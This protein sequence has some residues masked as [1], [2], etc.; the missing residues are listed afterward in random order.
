MSL[1]IL[2][3]RERQTT[4]KM[5]NE[6]PPSC[7]N[8]CM[9][10]VREEEA[11]KLFERKIRDRYECVEKTF[12]NEFIFKLKRINITSQFYFS[13]P[14]IRQLSIVTPELLKSVLGAL[15]EL[16]EYEFS[17]IYPSGCAGLAYLCE[18]REE[19]IEKENFEHF[20]ERLLSFNAHNFFYSKEFARVAALG[21]IVRWGSDDVI[22]QVRLSS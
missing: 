5:K 4:R 3:W 7:V 20:I 18:G 13:A 22:D 12:S 19:M 9:Q 10:R 6:A 14:L 11:I 16:I 21:S 8:N 17:D 15:V 2:E 1:T